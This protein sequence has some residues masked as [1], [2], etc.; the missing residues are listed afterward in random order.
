MDEIDIAQEYIRKR[1]TD[2]DDMLF[3]YECAR[4]PEPVDLL[5]RRYELLRMSMRLKEY[6]DV[7]EADD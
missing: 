7:Q 5:A 6:K 4:Q 3:V 1:L 2:L